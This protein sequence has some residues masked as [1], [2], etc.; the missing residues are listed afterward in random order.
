MALLTPHLVLDLTACQGIPGTHPRDGGLL[1]CLNIHSFHPTSPRNRGT[2][3][4]ECWTPL[5]PLETGH[6]TELQTHA[7]GPGG[8]LPG[9]DPTARARGQRT[10]RRG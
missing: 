1:K 5:P 9:L 2:L 3:T 8:P 7:L 10:Q 6:A 4:S